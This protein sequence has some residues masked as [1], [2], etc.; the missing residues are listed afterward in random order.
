LNA[1]FHDPAP[2][3]EVKLGHLPY[4]LLAGFKMVASV[5]PLLRV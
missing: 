2:I 3:S 1:V 4:V 5:L